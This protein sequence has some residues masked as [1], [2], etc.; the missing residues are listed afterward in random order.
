[1]GKAYVSNRYPGLTIS[2]P[3]VGD[4][5]FSDGVYVAAD[6]EEE[7]LIEGSSF[8]GVHIHPRDLPEERHTEIPV[9]HDD[10]PRRRGRGGLQGTYAS[11]ER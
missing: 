7:A 8:Y 3:K 9:T 1:M 5:R 10:P 2:R 4:I 11:E 6:A